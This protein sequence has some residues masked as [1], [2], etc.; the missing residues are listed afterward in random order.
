MSEAP[1]RS[2][3]NPLQPHPE[4]DY[5]RSSLGHRRGKPASGQEAQ[6]AADAAN[7]ESR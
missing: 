7:L 3:S 5:T 6:G 2:S 1:S 4:L